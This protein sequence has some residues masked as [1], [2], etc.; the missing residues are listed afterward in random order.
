[1]S[2]WLVLFINKSQIK[3]KV[4]YCFLYIIFARSS[5]WLVISNVV[6]NLGKQATTSDTLN[7]YKGQLKC[8][9]TFFKDY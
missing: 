2:S 3:E 5:K 8:T 9:Y 7:P 6:E 1:M 4:Q